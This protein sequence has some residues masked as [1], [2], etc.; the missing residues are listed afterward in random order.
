MM[1]TSRGRLPPEALIAHRSRVRE[2]WDLESGAVLL[3]AGLE[4]PVAEDLYARGVCLP[5]SAAL[6]IEGPA[7]Q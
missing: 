6:T 7:G 2:N 1:E 3:P 5:S 4:L